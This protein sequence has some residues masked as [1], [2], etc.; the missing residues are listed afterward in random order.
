MSAVI[1]NFAIPVSNCFSV[2]ATRPLVR[3]KPMRTWACTGPGAINPGTPTTQPAALGRRAA[4][5]VRYDR[6][7]FMK[8]T[9]SDV[10]L[11]GHAAFGILGTL[12]ALW[13]FV[14]ALNA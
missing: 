10:I 2:T 11:L 14:E 12:S 13:V 5:H 3:R 8:V 1:T 9:L 7:F 4:W 6:T